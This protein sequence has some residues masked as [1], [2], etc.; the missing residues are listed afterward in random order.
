MKLIKTF[1]FW[2][3]DLNLKY[4]SMISEDWIGKEID[5]NV[6]LDSI[7][8]KDEVYEV[9]EVL[10][11]TGDDW[12]CGPGYWDKTEDIEV[13][14][15][16]IECELEIP[17][18]W[19]DIN[20]NNWIKD[21]FVQFDPNDDWNCKLNIKLERVHMTGRSACMDKWSLNIMRNSK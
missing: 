14:I 4:N 11:R 3:N 8:N 20:I 17:D 2:E 7:I 21:N 9:I 15:Y 10:T 13:L 5:E 12:E 1:Q 6:K 16:K 19:T 18:D